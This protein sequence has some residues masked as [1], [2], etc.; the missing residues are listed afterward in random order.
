MDN[1][2]AVQY[3]FYLQKHNLHD[4]MQVKYAGTS[5][6]WIEKLTEDEV[7]MSLKNRFRFLSPLSLFLSLFRSF[8]LSLSL[9]RS[10]ARS[11]SLSIKRVLSPYR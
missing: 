10:L 3:L 5:G 4:L 11:L 6:I 2:F 1:T 9:A 7:V 8:F